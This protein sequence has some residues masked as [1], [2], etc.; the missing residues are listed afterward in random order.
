MKKIMRKNNLMEFYEKI[1]EQVGKNINL[2]QMI[3]PF[4]RCTQM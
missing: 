4:E 2:F 3:R 1:K